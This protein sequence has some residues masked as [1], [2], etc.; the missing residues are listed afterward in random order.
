[1]GL[2]RN[3]KM[4]TG[5]YRYLIERHCALNGCEQNTLE[6]HLWNLK[7]F[8][9]FN[10]N[11]E[12]T[13]KAVEN[14]KL[15]LIKRGYQANGINSCLSTLRILAVKLREDRLLEEDFSPTIKN[16]P[17]KP[18]NIS[19]LTV[20]E[21]IALIDCPR[22]WGPNKK[23]ADRRKFD[24]AIKLITY[25]CYRRETLL[26]LKVENIDFYQG[27]IRAIGKRSIIVTH[28]LPEELADELKDWVI[29]QGLKPNDWLFPG[30]GSFPMGSST[31]QNELKRRAK[32]LGITKRVNSQTLR[33][34]MITNLYLEARDAFGVQQFVGHRSI[35][36]TLRYIQLTPKDL[37]NIEEKHPINIYLKKKRMQTLNQV[38]EIPAPITISKPS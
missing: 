14:F 30:K 7:E 3:G 32:F 31:L 13:R 38:I 20:P 19:I 10:R 36:S 11:K 34:S 27:V 15:R 25:C 28:K 8:M 12:F 24:L 33:K 18:S 1:M 21:I 5:K 2:E 16:L 23:S 4:K 9:K 17:I 37:N 26:R 29:S 6:R 35:S 22:A